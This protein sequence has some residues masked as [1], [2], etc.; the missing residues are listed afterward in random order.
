MMPDKLIAQMS[1][2]ENSIKQVDLNLSLINLE[3]SAKLEALTLPYKRLQAVLNNFAINTSAIFDAIKNID[4]KGLK[5]FHEEFGWAEILPL[6]Y[7]MD[8]KE[9]LKNKGKEAVWQQF[10]EDFR[11]DEVIKELLGEVSKHKIIS[12]RNIIISKALNHHKNKDYI[13]SIPLLLSQIEGILWDYGIEKKKI[14]DEFNCQ[15]LIDENGNEII[16]NKLNKPKK[17]ELQQL[18]TLVFDGESKFKEELR[19][20]VYTSNFRNPILH[21]REINYGEEQRSVWLL[22]LL[23]TLLDKTRV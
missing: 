7:A 9:V 22:L 1:Q 2:F 10:I 4:Y 18:L 12:K 3:V 19:D 15:I 17:A 6:A 21:G 13:S 5:E 23:F 20:N 11:D 14:K 16:D 8:L